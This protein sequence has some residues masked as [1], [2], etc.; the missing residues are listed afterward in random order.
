MGGVV[1]GG[2]ARLLPALAGRTQVP[3]WWCIARYPFKEN[4]EEVFFLPNGGGV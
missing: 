2:G 1:G 4:K 3:L